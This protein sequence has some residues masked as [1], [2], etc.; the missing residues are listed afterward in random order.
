MHSNELHSAFESLDEP[1]HVATSISGALDD[2]NGWCS[3]L[4]QP[5]FHRD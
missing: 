2:D 1:R 4:Y 3:L 5:K